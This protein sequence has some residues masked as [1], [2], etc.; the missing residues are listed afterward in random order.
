MDRALIIIPVWKVVPPFSEDFE[1]RHAH[2][3][4][5]QQLYAYGVVGVVIFLG[6]YGSLFR[7]IRKLPSGLG[8]GPS[9]LACC[10]LS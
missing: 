6:L 1:A 7:L 10:C 5:L 4:L 2:N 8:G 3:E 9:F